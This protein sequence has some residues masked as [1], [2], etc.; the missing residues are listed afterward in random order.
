ITIGRFIAED[1]EQKNIY[2]LFPELLR[3]NLQINPVN[4]KTLF[5]NEPQSHREHRE[6]RIISSCLQKPMLFS[7]NLCYY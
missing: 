5:E 2:S 1:K 6:K 3:G 4:P 7:Q